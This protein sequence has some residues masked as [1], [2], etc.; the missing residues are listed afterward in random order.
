MI[1]KSAVTAIGTDSVTHHNAIH[2]VIESISYALSGIPIGGS[3][4]CK[5]MNSKGPDIRNILFCTDF[6]LLL[7]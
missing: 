4:Y 2:N 5:I 7:Y 3:K 1:G 6:I